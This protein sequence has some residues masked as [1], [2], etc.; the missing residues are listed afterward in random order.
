MANAGT[1]MEAALVVRCLGCQ[2]G[3]RKSVAGEC[4]LS[5]ELDW[6]HAGACGRFGRLTWQG[7]HAPFACPGG[8]G[9]VRK[10]WFTTASGGGSFP[11]QVT[12]QPNERTATRK[13]ATAIICLGSKVREVCPLWTDH[14]GLSPWLEAWW[15]NRSALGRAVRFG[16]EL[17]VSTRRVFRTRRFSP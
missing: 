9:H 1:A 14:R 3:D 4:A 12:M 16:S 2:P 13:G 7:S 15:S 10:A 17:T 6:L 5:T 11:V 8:T